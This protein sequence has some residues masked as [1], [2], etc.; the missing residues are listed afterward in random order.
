MTFFVPG[1]IPTLE[2]FN[3]ARTLGGSGFFINLSELASPMT[4]AG[5]TLAI[6]LGL[7]L[8]RRF[9]AIAGLAVAVGG[10]NAA[11]MLIKQL[12]ERPRPPMRYASFLEPGSS[13]PSGHATNAFALGVFGALFIVAH[14]PRGSARTLFVST[15]LI[16]A[17]L[18]AFARVYLGVHYLSDVL[19]GAVLGSVFGFLGAKVHASVRDYRTKRKN[20]SA[21]ATR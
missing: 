11:W 10:A 16:L 17:A 5:L 18:I 9:A 20:A 12:I 7:F 15:V 2:Y 13:F 3:T 8:R 21:T 6:G 1:D 14:I 4:T 19:A